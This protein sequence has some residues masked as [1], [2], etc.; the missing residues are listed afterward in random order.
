MGG[1]GFD[2]LRGTFSI[3]SL[4]RTAITFGIGGLA[5]GLL[6]KAWMMRKLKQAASSD[7]TDDDSP[8]PAT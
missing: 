1:A 3:V 7:A 5:F 4:I 8:P 2:L 6:M